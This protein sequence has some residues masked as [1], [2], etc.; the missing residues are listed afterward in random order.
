[1]LLSSM[2]PHQHTLLSYRNTLVSELYNWFLFALG[3]SDR[4]LI[5]NMNKYVSID[6]NYQSPLDI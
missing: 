3:I 4:D 5:N 1:M 2:K 6:Y